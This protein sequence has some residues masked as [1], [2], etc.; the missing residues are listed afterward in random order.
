MSPCC[1]SGSVLC[2]GNTKMNKQGKKLA[3]IELQFHICMCVHICVYVYR[4]RQRWQKIS[5]VEK[6]RDSLGGQRRPN[7]LSL[8]Q[9]WEV[10]GA[11]CFIQDWVREGIR[12]E[13]VNSISERVV[14]AEVCLK[15]SRIAS[16]RVVGVIRVR[17]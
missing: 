9:E 14:E 7:F 1:M 12:P 3:L 15:Y 11:C 4:D 10:G 5:T 6:N 8:S 13:E 16:E 17:A 2:A